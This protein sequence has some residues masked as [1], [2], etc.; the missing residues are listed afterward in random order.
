MQASSDDTH[1]RDAKCS[2]LSLHLQLALASDLFAPKSSQTDR[3]PGGSS[4]HSPPGVGWSVDEVVVVVVTL[5]LVVA[6]FPCA[7][8]LRTLPPRG[9]R[10]RG[11]E[12][13]PPL[14]EDVEGRAAE[15]GSRCTSQW[16]H[17][18]ATN[19]NY[20]TFGMLRRAL[21][22]VLVTVDQYEPLTQKSPVM[23]LR[24]ES[25]ALEAGAAATINRGLTRCGVGLD[26]DLTTLLGLQGNCG[27][28]FADSAIVL[29]A[30]R[31]NDL[32]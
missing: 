10:L 2:A 22:T 23:Y 21:L 25:P 1:V 30:D 5:V 12:E 18:N 17:D 14:L 11:D 31:K 27:P 8:P 16:H 26:A 4:Q 28:S 24:S 19:C 15:Q 3:S 9:V 32:T 29:Q 13:G 7:A 6:S 20:T